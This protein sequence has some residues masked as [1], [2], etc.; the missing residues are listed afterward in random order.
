VYTL[1][2]RLR[3]Q[4][5][6]RFEKLAPFTLIVRP[7]LIIRQAHKDI[8][9]YGEED[10]MGIALLSGHWMDGPS[11]YYIQ[12]GNLYVQGVWGYTPNH[13]QIKGFRSYNPAYDC[14]PGKEEGWED[15]PG[16]TTKL[17]LKIIAGL[18]S[19][20]IINEGCLS[21]GDD[22]P[23]GEIRYTERRTDKLRT[24]RNFAQ[25][26]AESYAQQCLDRDVVADNSIIKAT[27][28]RSWSKRG[29]KLVTFNCSMELI[30]R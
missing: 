28:L 9:R 3:K 2:S 27:L 24:S 15:V 1:T 22:T 11:A 13:M 16:D 18:P 8:N 12:D 10:I 20:A 25:D 23:N 29:D 21:W 5:L 4:Y 6:T 26:N 14:P 17:R 19:K 30:M 7:S